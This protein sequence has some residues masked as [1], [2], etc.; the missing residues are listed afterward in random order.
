MVD[1]LHP[2]RRSEIM[3]RVRGHDTKPEL[4]VR[5]LLHRLGFRF[6][7]HRRDMPGSPDI[8]LPRF[9]TVIFVHGCFWHG[10]TCRRGARPTTHVYILQ[11]EARWELPTYGD[12]R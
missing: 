9:Q 6:R 12:V 4:I 2:K 11:T 5:R 8:V 1:T 3:G 10:H 7:I